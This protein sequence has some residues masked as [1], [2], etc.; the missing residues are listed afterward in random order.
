[1]DECGL[2]VY[3][4]EKHEDVIKELAE[5][6]RNIDRYE[7]LAV[8]YGDVEQGIRRS[9]QESSLVMMMTDGKKPIC[10][11][12][13]SKERYEHGRVIWCLGTDDV[14]R[15]KKDFVLFSRCVLSWWSN[16]YG[17][18][19]NYVA[20]KNERSISW[21]KRMGAVFGSPRPINDEGDA[22]YASEV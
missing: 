10:I 4:K 15:H 1:M 12:G 16:Q 22:E 20:A 18:L 2:V 5:H 17:R 7:L 8:G 14:D 11:F 19:F 9:I 21:L 6:L 3:K 13:L